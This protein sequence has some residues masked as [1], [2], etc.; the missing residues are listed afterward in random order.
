MVVGNLRG[1]KP[2]RKAVR[3][4]Q[5]GHQ[6]IMVVSAMGKE[7]D[8]LLGV[9]MIGPRAADMI[10]QAVTALEYRASA[11]DVARIC[12]PHPTYTE[13]F[14]ATDASGNTTTVTSPANSLRV[15]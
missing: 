8:E 9:H 7:T 1:D 4:Q 11:E 10:A 3:A 12:H 13:T 14:K 5:Q 15:A 6:V 2:A